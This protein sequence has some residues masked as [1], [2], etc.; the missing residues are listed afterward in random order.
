MQYIVFTGTRNPGCDPPADR[1][2]GDGLEPRGCD[3]PFDSCLDTNDLGV[4]EGVPGTT[5]TSDVV[6]GITEPK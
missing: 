4:E 3:Q 6:F 2:D 5:K 1:F